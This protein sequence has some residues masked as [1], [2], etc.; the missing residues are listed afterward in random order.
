M[1]EETMD[2][3]RLTFLGT[4]TSIGVPMIGC[5]C[6]VCHSTDPHDK[7]LRASVLVETGGKRLLIDCGPD[8]RQQILRLGS[9]WLD[10]LLVTHTHYDHLGGID[11][12]RPYCQREGAFPVYCRSD[13]ARDIH[14]RMP[15]CFGAQHYPGA[16][17]YDLRIIDDRPFVAAG[18]PVTPLPVMHT[19]KLRITGFRIGALSYITDCKIMPSST[20]ELLKGTHT[21]V[22][23]ALRFKEHPSHLNISEAL[24]VIK[25]VK[26]RRALLT[27]ISHDL[28]FHAAV[29]RLLPDGVQLAFDGLTIEI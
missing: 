7:R 25:A 27:H 2:K 24:G 22:I 23:N 1:T 3:I 6:P 28:G 9:P 21:L 26:P 19:P 11:D 18:I 8:F 16:P 29:D 14:T 20:L 4:G 17:V 5:P 15:Y 13:V 12:L 10:A